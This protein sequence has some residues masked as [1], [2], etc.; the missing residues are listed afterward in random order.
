MTDEDAV[1]AGRKW[2]MTAVNEWAAEVWRGVTLGPGEEHEQWVRN[3]TALA[4]NIV[5]IVTKELEVAEQ[6]G[7]E[8]ERRSG[9]EFAAVMRAFYGVGEYAERTGN[10]TGADEDAPKAV[11]PND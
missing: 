6:R 10:A 8:A 7:R 1:A 3:C 5:S 9:A 4:A 2:V 11:R